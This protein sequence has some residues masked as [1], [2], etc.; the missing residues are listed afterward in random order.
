MN[1]SYRTIIIDI[2][3]T[4]F[5]LVYILFTLLIKVLKANTPIQEIVAGMI[6]IGFLVLIIS[7]I[8]YGITL[9]FSKKMKRKH[10]KRMRIVAV[11]Q[12]Y[13]AEFVFSISFDLRVK[14]RANELL[15]LVWTIF[16]VLIAVYIFWCSNIYKTLSEMKN[17]KVDIE[18]AN[19]TEDKLIN[20]FV[21]LSK[22]QKRNH[23]IRRNYLPAT[24]ILF[25]LVLLSSTTIFYYFDVEYNVLEETLLMFSLYATLTT[26]LIVIYEIVDFI[27]VAKEEALK[28]LPVDDEKVFIA[29]D[30]LYL[31]IRFK[32]VYSECKNIIEMTKENEEF[33]K[34]FYEDVVLTYNLVFNDEKAFDKNI[35]RITKICDDYKKKKKIM[36]KQHK[37]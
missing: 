34:S 20:E 1:K 4:F 14:D 5:A 28:I 13:L 12:L 29:E 27:K 23:F 24:I 10:I 37:M 15:L 21:A 2:L 11:I 17:D 30:K 32:K 36:K 33:D 16:A 6:T 8:T 7:Y 22:I 31:W 25:N 26:L 9:M 18:E 3:I 19:C 35:D